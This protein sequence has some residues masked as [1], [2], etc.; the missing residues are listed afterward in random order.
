MVRLWVQIVLYNKGARERSGIYGRAQEWELFEIVKRSFKI[1]KISEGKVFG[2]RKEVLKI[3][4]NLRQGGTRDREDR[5]RDRDKNVSRGVN[6]M[7]GRRV[8]RGELFRKFRGLRSGKKVRNKFVEA[9]PSFN[10]WIARGREEAGCD[11][12]DLFAMKSR[13]TRC[14]EGGRAG[15]E[16]AEVRTRK[17]KKRYLRYSESSGERFRWESR[18][19]PNSRRCEVF[20]FL[21]TKT[22]PIWNFLLCA[23]KGALCN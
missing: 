6:R 8:S 20:F 16:G 23:G 15:F 12:G 10:R 1:K 22:Y 18:S 5:D 21:L 19:Q 4:E 14:W 13:S 11:R 2:I 17:K 7:W 9:L 3:R